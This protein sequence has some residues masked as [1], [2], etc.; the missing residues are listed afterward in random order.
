MPE[1]TTLPTIV[2]DWFQAQGFTQVHFSGPS[3][4]ISTFNRAHMLVYKLRERPDHFTFY[5]E[6]T[7]GSLIVFEVSAVNGRA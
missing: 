1:R 3:E 4:R 5:K 6:A 2:E 7:G